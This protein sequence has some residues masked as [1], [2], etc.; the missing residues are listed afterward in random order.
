MKLC[1]MSRMSPPARQ[2]KTGVPWKEIFQEIGRFPLSTKILIAACLVYLAS[3]IDLIPDF[4][5]VIGQADDLLVLALLMKV[6]QKHAAGGSAEDLINKIRRA[7]RIQD[8]GLP[9]NNKRRAR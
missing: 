2:N 6:V 4:I 5:P 8:A 7:L 1:P 9:S 3:P